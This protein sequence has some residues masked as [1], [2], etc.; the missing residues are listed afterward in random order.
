MSAPAPIQLELP[1]PFA[2]GPVNAWLFVQPEVVLVDCGQDTPDCRA[3][4]WAGLAAHGV[5]PA[6]I[7]RIIITHPHVDH[8]GLAGALVAAGARSV[9]VS[10]AAYGWIADHPASWQT[11]VDYI[12]QIADTLG[13]PPEWRDAYVAFMRA[14]PALWGTIPPAALRRYPIDGQLEFGGL[15]W[16]VLYMPGHTQTQ[17]CF[18]APATGW[19]LSADML[20]ARAPVPVIEPP[21]DG[22]TDNRVRGLP[23]FVASLAQLATRPITRVFP[24]HGAPFDNAA[25][26]IARQQQRIAA[27]T[28]ET[29]AHVAAGQQTLVELLAA[30]YPDFP[31][32]ARFNALG[33]A[34]GYLD[35]LEAAGA[36]QFDPRDRVWRLPPA[37]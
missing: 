14:M 27:R 12:A 28:A 20:L 11:R 19:L 17:T 16:D 35:L 18:H 32:A 24:G 21:L 9:W 25:A 31:P 22:T 33:M 7:D 4:L 8:V 6:D 37:A 36:I 2:V 1:T 3:A 13:L 29:L 26:T 23:Q 5:T 15:T 34:L 30:L 10:D